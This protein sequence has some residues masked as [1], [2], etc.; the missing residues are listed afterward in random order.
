MS[1]K[2]QIKSVLQDIIKFGIY[3]YAT[4]LDEGSELENFKSAVEYFYL[5]Y[6]DIQ[7]ACQAAKKLYQQHSKDTVLV[8][9]NLDTITNFLW[10]EKTEFEWA[11]FLG[12]AATKSIIGPKPFV[13]MTNEFFLARFFG[14]KSTGDVLDEHKQFA[15]YKKWCSR[16]ALD[17]I[18]EELKA[19]WGLK[20]YARFTRGFYASYKLEY[21][22]LVYHAELNRKTYKAKER[23]RQ[24]S[25]ALAEV[26][27]KLNIPNPKK[28]TTA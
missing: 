28:R 9:V 5:N 23:K 24:E 16:Y 20:I 11:C 27:E 6:E 17:K 8:S 2:A 21:K 18:K 25:E 26:M 4:A 22:D 15:L 3:R 7:R 12:Y 14:Y 13:K 1:D 10:T 19:S